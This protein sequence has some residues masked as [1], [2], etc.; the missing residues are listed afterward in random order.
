MTAQ[1]QPPA[2]LLTE[3]H[4]PLLLSG[5]S[6]S[7][8]WSGEAQIMDPASGALLCIPCANRPGRR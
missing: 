7:A 4:Q 3:P 8:C 6:C 5:L 2:P 1:I